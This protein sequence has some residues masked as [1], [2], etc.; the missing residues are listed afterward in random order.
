M[1]EPANFD[2]CPLYRLKV[3]APLSGGNI[4]LKFE[5]YNNTYWQEIIATPVPGQWTELIYDFSGLPYN[6][7]IKMVIFP[8][9]Q[10][11]TPGNS[12]YIDDI[13]KDSCGT[14]E[15]LQLESNLP[16]VVIN[17]FGE[18]IVNEPKISAHMG[19]IDN[20]PGAVNNLYDG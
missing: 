4:T 15:P 13:L 20:G 5:N 17:T 11:T 1:D 3:L 8:D 16:I 6:D 7:L 2:L 14:P 19:V 18:Q 10:G 9:F 12:W